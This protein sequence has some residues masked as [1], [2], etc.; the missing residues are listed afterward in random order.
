MLTVLIPGAVSCL[1][2]LSTPV[3][4]VR[5]STQEY[6]QT[7]I[8]LSI[9]TDPGLHAS[10]PANPQPSSACC[11]IIRQNAAWHL[12]CLNWR[13]CKGPHD[14]SLRNLF[15]PGA[16]AMQCMPLVILLSGH[17][18]DDGTCDLPRINEYARAL[19]AAGSFFTSSLSANTALFLCC[20]PLILSLLHN[21]NV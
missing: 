11:S 9:F 13:F 7:L 4:Y 10:T 14:G 19:V 5:H 16:Q 17:L 2:V 6:D 20:I 18:L 1:T 21:M 12:F 15:R 8:M 3:S